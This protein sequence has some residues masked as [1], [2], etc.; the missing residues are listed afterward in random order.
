VSR[1]KTIGGYL[2]IIVATLLGAELLA[3]VWDWSPQVRNLDAGDALGQRRYDFSH[4]GYGDLV[5]H[6]DG[7]WIVWFHRPYHVQTNS[8][9][10][11][12]AEEP[13][14]AAVR[15]LAIG[16]SQTFGPYLAN[17]DTWPGWTENYLRQHYGNTEKVQVFNA[18]IAGYTILDELAFLKAKG[19]AFAPRLVILGAF[20]NDLV[21]LRKEKNQQV[22]RPTD[23]PRS[24]ASAALREAKRHS[25][26]A[27]VYDQIRDRVKFA[28]AGVDVRRGEANPVAPPASTPPADDMD[29]LATRYGELFREMATLLKERGIAFAVIFIPEAGRLAS[30][31]P[32]LLEP[33]LRSLAAQTATP[34]LDLTPH[35]RAERDPVVRLYLLQRD[36]KSGSLTGNGHLSREGN[37]VIGRVVA[38]WL[39]RERL[40]PQGMAR[41]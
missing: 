22:H 6:Q 17:E 32:S 16:D 24:Q 34:Y 29:R 12:N 41:P 37:A 21:D 1:S 38:D 28:L 26:L 18:G 15:I 33:L 3:R 40:L 31:E 11:R 14:D 27:S 9:G 25:A 39:L 13:S 20:E 23:P 35:M 10:L 36:G 19:L 30:G 5:P 8:V 2:A 4:A 7:H